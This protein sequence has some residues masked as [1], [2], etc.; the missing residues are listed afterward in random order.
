MSPVKKIYLSIIAFAILNILLIV[1]IVF[2]LLKE[3]KKNSEAFL[4]E[5]NKI[6]SL[7]KEEESRKKME[8]LYKNYQ[9]DLEEI[10]KVFVDPEVP[11]EFIGFLEKTAA[12]SQT[13]LKILSMTQKIEKEDP[14]PSLSFQ[15][16]AIGSFP[17]FL[18]F[19][20]KLENSPYLIEASELNARSL[21]E[22][23]IKSK[24]LENFPLADTNIF[25]TIRV[26]TK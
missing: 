14:W 26:F 1:F 8:D 9:S 20:E 13:Q 25:L 7:S 19:L 6:A 11:I 24:E 5:K 17:D 10:E 12:V 3:V 22:K 4:L 23:E 2:P 15:L 16:S 21:A 18:R